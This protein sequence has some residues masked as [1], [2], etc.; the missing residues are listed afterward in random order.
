MIIRNY[1]QLSK[2]SKLRKNALK[3]IEAGLE[4]V[5]TEK[6]IKEK[7]KLS[8][9]VLI[10]KDYNNKVQK[11]NLNKYKKIIVIGFGKSSAKMGKGIE[12]ILGK[13]IDKGLIISVEK[14]KLKKIENIKGTHPLPSLKNIKATKKIIALIENLTQDDLVICLISGGGSSLLCEPNIDFKKYFKIIEKNYKAGLDIK[15]FNELRR[16]LSKVKA[17]QLAK[18]TQAKIIS[19]IFSDVAG[20]D[21][22]IIASG[23]TIRKSKKVKNILLLNNKVALEVMEEKALSL[24]L[25]PIILTNKLKGEAKIAG[26]DVIKETRQKSFGHLGGRGNCFIFGGETTVFVRKKGKGGRNL[27]FCLGATKEI[28]KFKK[29]VLASINTDGLD[30][31]TDAAGA[32]IDEDSLDK[33][34]KKNLDYKECLENNA[35]YSF[36]KKMDDLIFTGPTGINIAD[37]GVIII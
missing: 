6:I 1:K 27:E 16:K 23:P 26:K 3:I 19:L 18:L 22:E 12:K 5:K 17:G 33:A 28:S 13:R 20:D 24:D 8:K 21:L 36:F 35:S 29:A 30:G 7:V 10:V 37:I 34:M 32:V 11:F 4:A 25:K 9:N 15:K 14:E 31:P 2:N